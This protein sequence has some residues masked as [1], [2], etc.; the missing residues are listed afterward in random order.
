MP[1]REERPITIECLMTYLLF[2]ASRPCLCCGRRWQ[3][4]GVRDA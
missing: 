4:I 3:W 1:K 2:G